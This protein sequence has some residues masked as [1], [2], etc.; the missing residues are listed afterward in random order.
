MLFA[1]GVA[2][3]VGTLTYSGGLCGV[4]T[5]V[6]ASN[7]FRNA[8]VTLRGPGVRVSGRGRIDRR[9]ELKFDNTFETYLR[10]RRVELRSVRVATDRANI[11]VTADVPLLGSRVIVL[12]RGG[13]EARL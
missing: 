1:T 7:D 12:L 9:G 8:D 11:S 6:T 5:Q 10:R 4:R 3:V 13:D 2:W